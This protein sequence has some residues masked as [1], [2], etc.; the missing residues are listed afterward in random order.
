MKAPKV[1]I[2]YSNFQRK[3]KDS[4]NSRKN[5]A[6]G[7]NVLVKQDRTMQ[8]EE[9]LITPKSAALNHMSR[10]LSEKLFLSL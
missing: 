3:Q 4:H 6:R 2:R 9:L 10:P 1:R 7:C 8:I 5:W